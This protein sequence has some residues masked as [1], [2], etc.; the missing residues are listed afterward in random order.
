M[1]SCK[2]QLQIMKTLT[3]LIK[4]TFMTNSTSNACKI[5]TLSLSQQQLTTSEDPWIRS[6]RWLIHSGLA[7]TIIRKTVILWCLN[8]RWAWHEV[9]TSMALDLYKTALARLRTISSLHL[10]RIKLCSKKLIS[11]VSYKIMVN[12]DRIRIMTRLQVQWVAM[13]S[14]E[15]SAVF[16]TKLAMCKIMFLR[17]VTLIRLKA[18]PSQV[19]STVTVHVTSTMD[20]A[21]HSLA[22][23]ILT[24]T[25]SCL[26]TFLVAI[27]HLSLL[28]RSHMLSLSRTQSR[29]T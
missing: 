2:I 28:R 24:L 18:R 12:T 20:L 10:R 19:T 17:T 22:I 3:E 4:P 11:L 29:L 26:R 16:A 8:Q 21:C 15:C 5:I 23:V 27:R 7:S 25:S 1:A 13:T 14:K 6:H 9:S